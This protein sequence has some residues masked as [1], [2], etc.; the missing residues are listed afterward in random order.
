MAAAEEEAA[1]G[2]VEAAEV[3]TL[4]LTGTTQPMAGFME[5]NVPT[6]GGVSLAKNLTRLGATGA[7][8]YSTSTR[9]TRI[10]SISRRF[11]KAGKMMGRS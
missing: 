3:T 11:I 1:G 5:W 7:C 8:M 2:D 9:V 4:D 10:P 6:S